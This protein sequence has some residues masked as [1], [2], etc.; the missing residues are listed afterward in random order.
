MNGRTTAIGLVLLLSVSV[1]AGAGLATAQ[2]QPTVSVGSDQVSSGSEAGVDVTL[3]EAPDG[4]QTYQVTIELE[5]P[6]VANITG[7]RPGEVRGDGFSVVRM[8]ES[9]IT[10]RAADFNERVEKGASRVQLGT[11][12]FNDTYGGRSDISVTVDT[13]RD[14]NNSVFQ[15]DTSSGELIISG[16]TPRPTATATPT[17]TPTPTTTSTPTPTTTAPPT[18]EPDGAGDGTTAVETTTADSGTPLENTIPP[19][20]GDDGND[21][22]DGSDDD[23][24][25]TTETSSGS[26]P[27]FT[28]ALAVLAVAAV[29]LFARRRA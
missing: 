16:G 12:L 2:S 13:L 28:A 11:V 9:S 23:G 21:G 3:D 15:A 27:G 29:A 26:G 1:F 19:A 8:S 22:D 24:T 5:D 25:T 18:T 14:D 7:A 20:D 17:A 6:R 10:L 4:L